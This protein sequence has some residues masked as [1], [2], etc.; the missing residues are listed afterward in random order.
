MVSVTVVDPLEGAFRWPA[1]VTPAELSA[2]TGGKVAA[3]DPRVPVLLAGASAGI[4]RACGWHVAPVVDET[5][6]LDGPGS[7]V[8][9][10]RTGRLVAV[11]A[12]V[13]GGEVLTDGTDVLDGDLT[14]SAFFWSGDGWVRR[15]SGRFTS[16][17]RG[18]SVSIR[19]GW[20]LADVPDVQ[21]IVS[22]VVAVALSSPMGATREQAGTVSVSWATTSPGVAGGLALLERDWAM[23]APFM[24]GA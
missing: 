9:M 11:D 1:F 19:H 18:V 3:D 21:A 15:V 2:A 5:V 13:D 8:L 16:R 7:D 20:D 22:Q 4:R 17:E 12:V 10:L 23:L 24:L 6:T 14:S